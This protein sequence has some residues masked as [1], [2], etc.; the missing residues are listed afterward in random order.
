M[1][2]AAASV[3]LLAAL[4]AA[5]CGSNGGEAVWGGP[6][7]PAAEGEI[8]VAGFNDFLAEEER[9]FERSPALSAAE[10]LRVDLPDVP[11]NIS[12]ISKAGAV[13][14]GPATVVVLVHLPPG[15]SIRSTRHTIGLERQSDG[16]WRLSSARR[17]QRCWP[18]R[19]HQAFSPDRCG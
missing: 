19:G 10:F 3:A 1:K 16:T 4:V 11:S 12:I 2:R 18:G 8:D 15:M 17:A 13:G 7:P 9:A 6:P 14:G 5:S